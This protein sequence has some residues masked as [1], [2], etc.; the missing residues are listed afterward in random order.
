MTNEPKNII[1][2]MIERVRR[3]RAE[4]DEVERE[5]Q[6]YAREREEAARRIAALEAEVRA[7]GV[8]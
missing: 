6:Q 1:D 7:R 4:L 5:L 8:R 3:H 2:R